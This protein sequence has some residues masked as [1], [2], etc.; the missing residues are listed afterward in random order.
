LVGYLYTYPK[1]DE[2]SQIKLIKKSELEENKALVD[3]FKKFF[4]NIKSERVGQNGIMMCNL[5]Q[6]NFKKFTEVDSD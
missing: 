6:K 1:N 4:G 2:N 3:A 5:D